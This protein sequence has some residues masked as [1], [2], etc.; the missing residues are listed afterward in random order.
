MP[1]DGYVDSRS[2]WK[3]VLIG[4]KQAGML[5]FLRKSEAFVIST[6][7]AVVSTSCI[8]S[9]RGVFVDSG[10]NEGS[11]SLLAAAAGCDAFAVEA[12]PL[13]IQELDAAHRANSPDIQH[14]LKT[15]NNMLSRVCIS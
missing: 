11:Y 7:F 14:R 12:Q 4:K 15:F 5:Q 3:V 9:P 10:A 8:N 1:D 13:C 2:Y 6:V